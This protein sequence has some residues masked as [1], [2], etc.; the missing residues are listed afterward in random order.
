MSKPRWIL[1][2]TSDHF[3]HSL[4]NPIYRTL[5]HLNLS[6]GNAFLIPTNISILSTKTIRKRQE[7]LISIYKK[8]DSTVTKT[9]HL[10]LYTLSFTMPLLCRRQK[11][12]VPLFTDP[13]WI[14]LT[15]ILL[16]LFCNTCHETNK[17]TKK[18]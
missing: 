2:N 14:K 8:K 16:F 11:S 17:Q 18:N 9:H 7:I 4:N 6:S 3:L 13:S 12:Q 1:I 15:I 10:T 5:L